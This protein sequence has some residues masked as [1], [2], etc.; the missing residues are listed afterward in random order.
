MNG[1]SSNDTVPN[2]SRGGFPLETGRGLITIN[3]KCPPGSFRGLRLD[4]G[5]GTFAHYSSIIQKLEIFEKVVSGKDGRVALAIFD[6]NI[7]VGY[8]VCWYPD[9]TDRWSKLGELMYEFGAIEVS[10]DFRK[11]GIAGEMVSS[12]LREDF[13]DE[14]ISYMNG[15]SWH[16]DVD[17]SGLTLIQYRKMMLNVMKPFGFEE[18]YTN[19]PNI[20]LRQENLF[21]ARI[22]SKVSEEDQLRFRN[23]RFGIVNR[24]K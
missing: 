12:A 1:G 2:D 23:L 20:A 17:G 22:G 5:L 9:S 3:P 15:Y 21:M 11:M 8:M 13:F 10:R 18:Y 16:W 6:E 14:K 19:E 7:I 24:K 4:A